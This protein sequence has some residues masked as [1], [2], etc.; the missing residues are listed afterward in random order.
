MAEIKVA[1]LIAEIKLR[2]EKFKRE[3]NAIKQSVDKRVNQMVDEFKKVER[4]GLFSFR[5]LA[6][7]A[8][9]ALGGI[10]AFV[11]ARGLFRGFKT[12]ITLASDTTESMN[13]V[14]EVFGKSAVSVIK[15]SENAATA[16]G[17]TKES[18]LAMTGEVGNLLVAMGSTEE[19][20]AKMSTDVLQLAADL[21]SFNN[22]PTTQAL[23]AIRAALIGETEPMRRFGSNV[24]AAR[25]EALALSK[26]IDKTTL[27]TNE[28]MKAQLRLE[29]IFKDTGKA[30]GDFARTSNDF[31]NLM[32]TLG[33]LLSDAAAR[34]GAALIPKLTKF[35]RVIKNIVTSSKFDVFIG[36]VAKA[37]GGVADAAAGATKAIV[38]FVSTATEKRIK[39]LQIAIANTEEGL[40]QIN[41][42]DR[43]VINKFLEKFFPDKMAANRAK[44]IDFLKEK[45][46]AM[47]AELIELQTIASG[48]GATGIIGKITGGGSADEPGSPTKVKK[49]RRDPRS[50]K[51][52]LD[53]L[54]KTL[55]RLQDEADKTDQ[56][57]TD[58]LEESADAAEKLNDELKG[59]AERLGTAIRSG[60][61]FIKVLIRIGLQKLALSL[62]GP[63]GIAV[64]F[65][66]GFF[67]QG[68]GGRMSPTGHI[69]AATGLSGT[70]PQGFSQ[71]NFLIGVNSGETVD[72]KTPAQAGASGR[73]N[74]KI[75]GSL[76]ALNANVSLLG[77]R[78]DV[79]EA[80][81]NV[82]ARDLHLM[83]KKQTQRES[84]FF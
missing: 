52:S 82:G 2:D 83:I 36:A 49:E 33:A 30:Q 57:L 45:L 40:K 14:K 73:T 79:I 38:N 39:N 46:A 69:Q 3:L 22:V 70:V 8:A 58:S 42:G 44:N 18:A 77:Q 84:R 17:A 4:K 20:A 67:A 6:A 75:L 34:L 26:G 51:T 28:M 65:A 9:K 29:I 35:A 64:S 1:D 24:S 43:G 23:N 60:E 16:L 54:N 81:V 74:E 66:S 61:D 55:K 47:K 68:G 25:V 48:A 11:A 37:F 10:F 59:V 76:N 32:K 12:M 62:A 31:A 41:A 71:D 50:T 7:G 21:G 15:F 78:Q 72:I 80:S 5:K 56:A 27:A 13:K 63:L 53:E 19:A